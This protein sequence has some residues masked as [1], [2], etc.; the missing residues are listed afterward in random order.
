MSTITCNDQHI[1]SFGDY[2]V[3]YLYSNLWF[4][5]KIYIKIIIIIQRIGDHTTCTSGLLLFM[6]VFFFKTDSSV[7]KQLTRILRPLDIFHQSS[8]VSFKNNVGFGFRNLKIGE[9]MYNFQIKTTHW[10]SVTNQL[11]NTYSN[12]AIHF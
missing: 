3:P 10:I 6:R 1:V 8:R 2:A 12:L 4:L 7:S 11:Q 5:H 9:R